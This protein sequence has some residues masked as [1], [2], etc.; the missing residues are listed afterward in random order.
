MEAFVL[1]LPDLLT[2]YKWAIDPKSQTQIELH[3]CF[4]IVSHDTFGGDR[5]RMTSLQSESSDFIAS[6]AISAQFA[7][8]LILTVRKHFFIFQSNG[9]LD[10]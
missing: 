1:Y 9:N 4:N 7:L 8:K 3:V 2:Y 6:H 10:H 5:S